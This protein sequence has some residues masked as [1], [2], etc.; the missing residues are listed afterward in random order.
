VR[1]CSFG[2]RNRTLLQALVARQ[3]EGRFTGIDPDPQVLAI[4]RRRLQSSTPT[5]EL[6]ES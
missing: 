1:R 4:A 5:V 6:V 3:P 2:L